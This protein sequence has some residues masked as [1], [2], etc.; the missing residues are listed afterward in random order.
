MG[1]YALAAQDWLVWRFLLSPSHIGLAGVALS[2][3]KKGY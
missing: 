1:E 2:A 3:P